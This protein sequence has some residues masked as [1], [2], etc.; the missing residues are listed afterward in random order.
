MYISS[1]E[2]KPFSNYIYRIS[3]L[4]T[5]VDVYI[6]KIKHD[7]SFFS[8]LTRERKRKETLSPCY[9][10]YNETPIRLF[11]SLGKRFLV[12]L[13]SYNRTYADCQQQIT[14]EF[15]DFDFD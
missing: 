7:P 15:Q 6:V 5:S 4:R 13:L 14:V 9:F 12:A 8:R 1:Y 10:F 11:E 2:P 3:C